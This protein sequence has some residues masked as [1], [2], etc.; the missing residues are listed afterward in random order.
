MK[1]YLKEL[2]RKVAKETTGWDEA[3]PR[4]LADDAI[5]IEKS[6][7]LLTAITFPRYVPDPSII[8]VFFDASMQG[9]G[10]V[11]FLTD[12]Y[13]CNYYLYA[14]SRLAPLKK[15]RTIPELELAA[16]TEAVKNVPL[17]RKYYDKEDVE[18]VIWTDS[19]IIL[20]RLANDLNKHGPYVSNRLLRVH[21]ICDEFPMKF[22]HVVTEKN[23]A[24]YYSRP[25]TISQFMKSKPYQL[26]MGISVM[27]EEAEKCN[28]P[29]VDLCCI[30]KE[31]QKKLINQNVEIPGYESV[32]DWG[33]MVSRTITIIRF[34][35]YKIGYPKEVVVQHALVYLYRRIQMICLENLS[36][37]VGKLPVEKDGFGVI[38]IRTRNSEDRPIWI[39]RESRMALM[40]V[41]HYHSQARHMRRRYTKALINEKFYIQGINRLIDRVLKTC[42][43][44][45]KARHQII[46]QPTSD[47]PNFRTQTY[48]P[49]ECVGLDY[50]GPLK[51]TTGRKV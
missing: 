28:L 31:S 40:I 17:I 29:K 50:F 32:S 23:P 22:R 47:L 14:K 51:L 42:V 12:C 34:A 18:I 7:P 45:Q 48:N 24:D 9:Y 27:L 20:S 11:V 26:E 46:D 30:T 44:C 4:D 2:F 49:F 5:M 41:R 35:F 1:L 38:R 21:R 39:P 25:K 37:E 33:R 36:K 19:S 6:L 43:P 16:L 8:S 3:L 15:P 13:D 10:F